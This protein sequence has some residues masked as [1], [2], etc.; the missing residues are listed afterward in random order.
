MTGPEHYRRAEALLEYQQRPG[1]TDVDDEGRTVESYA[2]VT[3]DDDPADPRDLSR[4]PLM[5]AQVHATLAL[6]AATAYA[7]EKDYL[8]DESSSPR[9]W[10]AAIS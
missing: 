3:G 10:T 2:P 1:W 7:A 9:E 8:G 6:A 5:A 4:N